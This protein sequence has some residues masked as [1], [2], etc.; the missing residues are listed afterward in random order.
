MSM[1]ED[2]QESFLGRV[3]NHNNPTAWAVTLQLNGSPSTFLIDTGAEVTVISEDTH[4]SLGNP[5]LS[6]PPRSLKG[7]SNHTLPVK[8]F[9]S[10]LLKC[11]HNETRQDVYVVKRLHQQLLGRPAIVA[12]GLVVRTGA[13]TTLLKW[14]MKDFPRL[15]KGL[16]SLDYPY[17]IQLRPGAI[18]FSQPVVRR[19]AIPLMQP[20]KQELERMERLRVIARVEQPTDWCAGMVVVQKPNGKVRICVDLTR[21]NESVRRERHPLPS[22]D[23][24]LAQLSGATIFSKLDANSGFWQVPLSQESAL[25]TTFITPFGR[26]CFHRLPFGISSAPEIFQ[27]MM[28]Q[29]L[30]G[31]PGTVCM[32]DDV[33]VFGETQEEHDERLRTVLKRIQD[34]GMTLNPEKCEF[35]RNRVKFLGHVLDGTGIHPD[36]DKIQGIAETATPK[37][38]SDIRRFLGTVNQMSKFSPHLAD[39]TRPL[40]ELLGKESVWHWGD[41]QQEAFDSIKS[42]LTSAP[43]LAMFDPNRETILSADAS[44][45]GIGAVLLQ[46]QDNGEFK[47]V[48]YKSRALTPTE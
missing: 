18:P 44:S 47:P 25:L 39:S 5:T 42:Q 14:P 17:T 6:P 15:F 1:Q 29:M 41:Q 36:P 23:Q 43:V 27:R 3:T 30:S 7:P 24:V 34:S 45:Y 28:S 32:M 12:L 46:K 22:V 33:L 8:G 10:A 19:V 13:I 2:D 11:D 35:S 16:G 31:L 40:R 21:L 48:A 38:V 4:D 26:F 9:F 20:V 37:D